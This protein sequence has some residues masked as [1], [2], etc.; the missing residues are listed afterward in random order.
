M[1]ASRFGIG[2]SSQG[3]SS[4]RNAVLVAVLSAV[5]AGALIYLFV[6]HYKK[7]TV[8]PVVTPPASTVWVATR[9]I[10]AG[11]PEAE[12][13]LQG[14]FKPE[15]T[16]SVTPGAI[17]DPSQIVGE[18]TQKAIAKGEQVTAAEFTKASTAAGATTLAGGLD[19]AASL[20]KNQ[21]AVAFSFD[22]EHGL[23]SWL[24]VG[25]TVDVMVV[26]KASTELV[27]QNVTVLAN[28]QGMVVLKLTDKQA[29]LV[30]AATTKG[31]L[32]L[33]LRPA[34]SATNS[35]PIYAQGS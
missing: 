28:E 17:A 23:T 15:Q 26:K 22:N 31:S 2:G 13:A 32:W 21:R 27:D 33:S 4:R 29:L 12:V 35:I 19:L 30:T 8:P 14:F 10:P 34:L 5:L 7:N 25:D 11:T 3:L 20:T 18:V 6:S 24:A 9:A 16:T 1:E